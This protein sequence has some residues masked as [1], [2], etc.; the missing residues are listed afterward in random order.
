MLVPNCPRV[1]A[2]FAVGAC[3]SA[4]DLRQGTGRTAGIAIAA[5]LT[6]APVCAPVPPEQAEE[7]A[8]EATSRGPTPAF[9]E[10]APRRKRN[11]TGPES[12]FMKSKDR[13]VQPYNARVA[14]T[15]SADHCGAGRDAELCRLWPTSADDRRRRGQSGSQARAAEVAPPA[16]RNALTI[17]VSPQRNLWN[18][19][20]MRTSTLIAAAILSIASF[21]HAIGKKAVRH[22]HSAQAQQQTMYHSKPYRPATGYRYDWQ[23]GDCDITNKVSLNTC[24]NGGR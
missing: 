17:R 5:R 8:E 14:M 23:A 20:I 4:R 21:D 16:S 13:F 9:P 3:T 15:P 18:R 7:K 1:P 19:W 11:F 6:R 22:P 24:T 12:R 2:R 10:Q